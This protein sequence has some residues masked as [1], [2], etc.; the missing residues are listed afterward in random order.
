MFYTSICM[1]YMKQYMKSRMIYRTDFLVDFFSNLLNQCINLLFIFI[2]FAKVPTLSG[3]S[4]EEIVFI[5]GYF[6]IPYAIFDTFWGNLWNVQDRYI[7]KGEM[8]RILTRPVYSLFQI[9]LETMTLESLSGVITG[10]AVMVYSGNQLH[11]SFQW[12]DSFVLLLLVLGSN[13]VYGGIYVTLASIGFWTDSKT[14]IIPLIYNI[15]S[16]GRYPVDIYN[17]AIRALLTWVLPFAFVGVYPAMYFL[18]KPGYLLWT[19][20]TPIVGAIAMT[21]GIFVWN[22]G[23]KRY[24]G[25]GS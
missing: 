21:I 18:H 12:Y 3:W 1:D 25:A 13:F 23:I 22:A 17:K 20:L 4:R 14:G 16:Y 9:L 2:V 6:L 7:I 19:I 15:G 24:R 10:I 11:L 5:Y 8:D